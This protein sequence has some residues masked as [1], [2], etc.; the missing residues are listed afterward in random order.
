MITVLPIPVPDMME[1]SN[2]AISAKAAQSCNSLGTIILPLS[3]YM[4]RDAFK[5]LL[6]SLEARVSKNCI[7]CARFTGIIS[8]VIA[9]RD[10]SCQ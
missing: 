10:Q 1:V 7:E 8:F 9:S 2:P 5:A 3:T 6:C 4:M